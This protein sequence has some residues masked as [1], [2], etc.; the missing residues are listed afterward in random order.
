MNNCNIQ[1]L[2][3]KKCRQ[4]ILNKDQCTALI[5]AH[6]D[7]DYQGD[8]VSVTEETLIFVD[9]SCLPEWIKASVEEEQWAKGKLNCPSCNAR[10]GAFDFV[11]G[12]KCDC[13]T[14]VLP[15]VYFIKSKVDLLK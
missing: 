13:K 6:N 1:H 5:N 7:K 10:V 14:S 2:K 9:E 15:A 8:C 3:C 12:I 4:V 11:S